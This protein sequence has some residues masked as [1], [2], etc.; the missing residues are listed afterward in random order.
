MVYIY[1]YIRNKPASISMFGFDDVYRFSPGCFT[2]LR[3]EV[4]VGRLES[5]ATKR[6]L[7]CTS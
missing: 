7:L 6:N 3:S 1:I 4:V 5:S 2:K